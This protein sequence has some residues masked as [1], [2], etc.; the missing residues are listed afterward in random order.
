MKQSIILVALLAAMAPAIAAQ[1][2]GH[3]HHG[4]QE[5]IEEWT[6]TPYMSARRGRGGLI[7]QLEGI[8][9]EQIKVFPSVK[10]DPDQ[11]TYELEVKN[12]TALMPL[13]D[14]GAWHLAVASQSQNDTLVSV[15][16]APYFSKPGENPEH[17]LGSRR[18]DLE[19]VPVKLPREHAYYRAGQTWLF[20]V[21]YLGKPAGEKSVVFETSNGTRTLIDTDQ[22]GSFSITF[23][24]DFP[25]SMEEAATEHRPPKAK[26]VLSARHKPGDQMYY[27]TFSMDYQ[28]GPHT[29]R[30]TLLGGG[31]ALLGMLL[32][33]PLLRRREKSNG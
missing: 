18:A 19:I 20:Q 2:D 25:D 24:H 33:A 3:Q 5:Q 21:R 22:Q 29:G 23:P 28:I 4:M 12:G 10:Q 9:S 31:F 7:L 11:A 26:F 17:M 27:S 8:Q 1:Q 15:T 14:H 16:T 6:S 13:R 30:S 32:A